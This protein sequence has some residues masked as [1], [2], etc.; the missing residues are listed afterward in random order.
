MRTLLVF[1]VLLNVG[2]STTAVLDRSIYKKVFYSTQSAEQLNETECKH[3]EL[4]K[5]HKWTEFGGR[6]HDL[7]KDG[8]ICKEDK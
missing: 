3:V 7:N 1:V 8:F 6:L 5:I 4:N 2:C